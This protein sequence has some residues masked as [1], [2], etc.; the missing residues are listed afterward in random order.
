MHVCPVTDAP[1]TPAPA[2]S[3]SVSNRVN[4]VPETQNDSSVIAEVRQSIVMRSQ[5]YASMA[6][7][8]ALIAGVSLTF[9]VEADLEQFGGKFQRS[10]ESTLSRCNDVA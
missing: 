6:V 10:H 3:A 5:A 9:L 7:V 1:N 2:Y 4:Q 8:A